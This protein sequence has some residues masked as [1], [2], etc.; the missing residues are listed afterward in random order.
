MQQGRGQGKSKAKLQCAGLPKLAA[1]SV[2]VE[3]GERSYEG[4]AEADIKPCG[5]GDGE[6]EDDRRSKDHCFNVRQRDVH[7][8]EREAHEHNRYECRRNDPQGAPSED[9][10]PEADCNHREDVIQ[11]EE[12]M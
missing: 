12:G 4:G 10:G 6:P 5:Y 3:Q 8:G 2:T 9:A 11:S 1:M 7:Q